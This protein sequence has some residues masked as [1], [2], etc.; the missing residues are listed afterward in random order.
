[1]R[2]PGVKRIGMAGRWLRSRL[3]NSGLILGYHRISENPEDVYSLCVR[4]QHFAE[5][6]EVLRQ[7]A[8]PI[9]L[10]ELIHGLQSDTLPPRS[11]A[12]TFDDGYADNLYEAMPLLMQY[13]IP[14]TLFVTTGTL[15]RHFW[16]DELACHLIDNPKLPEELFVKVDDKVHYW[17][18]SQNHYEDRHQILGQIYQFLLGLTVE[19]RQRAMDQL[20][21]QIDGA[22]NQEECSGRALT[23]E[24][25]KEFSKSEL[26]TIGAH[27]VTHPFLTNLSEEAQ[28]WEIEQCKH[29]LEGLLEQP[30]KAFSYPNGDNNETTQALLRQAGYT[31]A[32]ASYNDVTTAS[33]DLF[34]LPRFWVPDQGSSI[35]AHWLNRWLKWKAVSKPGNP[36]YIVY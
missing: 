10:D 1:M 32:C 3:V 26:V 27:A 15:G 14:A 4:P 28:L 11:V 25:L 36:L 18:V 21:Q 2:V 8:N 23:T 33:C 7:Y 20:S 31:S 12:V 6:L 16:W 22:H 9:P 17:Q 29:D 19:A 30:I 34:N 5:Q 24:E 13:G 35:F